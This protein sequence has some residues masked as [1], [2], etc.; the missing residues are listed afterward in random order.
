MSA[1]RD[2]LRKYGL[3]TAITL[4]CLEIASCV[5]VRFMKARGLFYEPP[6]AAG[7]ATYLAARDPV[8]GW[9]APSKFGQGDTDAAGSRVVPAFP[10]PKAK[11]C[12]SIY[13]D[14]FAW[15]EEASHE[16]AWGN[17]LAQ[18]ANCRVTNF[19]VVGYGTDQ[20]YLRYSRNKADQAPV[21]VLSHLSENILRNVNRFRNLLAPTDVIALKPRFVVGPSGELVLVP[22][23]APASPAELDDLL[24][25]P[26]RHLVDEYFAPGGPSG[27]RRVELPYTLSIKRLFSNYRMRATFEGRPP[28]AAFYDANHPARGLAVSAGIAKA[29]AREATARGASPLVLLIPLVPDFADREKTGKWVYAPLMEE[30][31]RAG[32][33]YLDSGDR[34]LKVLAGRDPCS[35]YVRCAGGHFNE[36]G[37]R[38]LAELVHGWFREKGQL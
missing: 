1:L 37:Y 20:A 25:Y 23:A 22:M 31:D 11:V 6:A 26:E 12:A 35:L 13:G 14:S 17:V 30:L 7:R 15:G 4:S 2:K 38:L 34:F 21:V 19:G 18:R 28:H 10:D 27:V 8:L 3:V 16:H 36:E 33:A 9:P 29:F 24:A 5:G 32:V